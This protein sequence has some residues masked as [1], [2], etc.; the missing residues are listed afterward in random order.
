MSQQ[1]TSPIDEPADLE[2]VFVTRMKRER[3]RRG[4]SQAEL[5]LRVSRAGGHG[6]RHAVRDQGGGGGDAGAGGVVDAPREAD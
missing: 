6:P 1:P 4:W 3:T 2:T 5:A